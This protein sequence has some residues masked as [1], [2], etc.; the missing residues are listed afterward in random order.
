MS[1][2]LPSNATKRWKR[3]G[4]VLVLATVA[5]VPLGTWAWKRYYPVYPFGHSHACSK[6]LALGLQMYANDH[7]GWMPHGGSTPEGSLSFVCTN[8]DPYLVKQFLRGKHLSETVVD[9]QLR[10][11]GVLSPETCGWHYVEGLREG[12]SYELAMAWDKKTGLSHHGRYFADLQCE[13]VML[14]GSAQQIQKKDWPAFCAKQ[15]QLL[16][17]VIASRGPNDPPVRWSDEQALGPNVAT[18]RTSNP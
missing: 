17:E 12:D 8:G 18:R 11:K 7:G 3:V 16:A 2:S 5:L 14:D 13:V 15:K 1:A 10:R 4:F 9:T 6:N